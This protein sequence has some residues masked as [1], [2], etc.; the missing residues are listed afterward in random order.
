LVQHSVFGRLGAWGKERMKAVTKTTNNDDDNPRLRALEEGKVQMWADWYTLLNAQRIYHTASDFSL[1]AAR[2]NR[3]IE[4][5][6]IRGRSVDDG[7]L[8]SAKLLL[9]SDFEEE[10]EDYMLQLVQRN[11]TQ[12]QYCN[13]EPKIR[14]RTKADKAIKTK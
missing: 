5:W 3:R 4:S 8:P 6:T 11:S 13:G 2:W 10:N 7:S 1:S 14:R 9:Q 12:L